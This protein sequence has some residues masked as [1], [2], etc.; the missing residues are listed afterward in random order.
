M[1]RTSHHSTGATLGRA[2]L[3][4]AHP[5]HEL[6]LMG[7]LAMSQP[8]VFVMTDGSGQLGRS[9]LHST[10]KT[11]LRSGARPG[12]MYGHLSDQEVYEA[13]LDQDVSLPA[14]YRRA[15]RLPLSR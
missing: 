2:A 15:R 10:T 14:P 1:L 7:W 12:S 13:M 5:G 9:R 8:S 3:I 4:V 6:N 11:L